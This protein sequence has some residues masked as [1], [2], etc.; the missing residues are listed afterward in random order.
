MRLRS[1][2]GVVI[3]RP[4]NPEDVLLVS[5]EDPAD[6]NAEDQLKSASNLDA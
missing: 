1:G 4:K 2:P 3:S 6:Q 5:A